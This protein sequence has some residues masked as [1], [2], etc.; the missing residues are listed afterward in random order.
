M[1]GLPGR[2]KYVPGSYKAGGNVS[3]PRGP[4]SSPLAEGRDKRKILLKSNRTKQFRSGSIALGRNGA[5]AFF[6]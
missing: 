4:E 1:Y 5:R 3:R 2:I 6:T